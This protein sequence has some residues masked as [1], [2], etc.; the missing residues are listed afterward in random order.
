[1]KNRKRNERM[2]LVFGKEKEK[3]KDMVA[4]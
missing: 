3:E 4:P 2:K 1:L